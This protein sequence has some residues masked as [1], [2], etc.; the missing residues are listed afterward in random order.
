[1]VRGALLNF[2]KWGTNYRIYVILVSLLAFT[3]IRADYV[4]SYAINMELAV[5]PYFF[6]F[7][8]D[9]GITRM[10]FYFGVVLLFCNAPFV[11]NQQ[12]FVL[13]R[14]GRKHWFLGQMLYIL[15]ANLCFFLVTAVASVIVFVPQ[16]SFS[17]DW[18][19][20][21]RICAENN[22]AA[23]VIMHQEIIEYFEPWMAC[24]L[25]YVLNVAIGTFLGLVIF[26]GNLFR[27]RIFGPAIATGWIVLSNMIDVTQVEALKYISPVHWGT[28]YTLVRRDK[29]IPAWYVAAF[30]ICGSVFMG[31]LIMKKSKRYSLDAL[32]EI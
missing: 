12:M 19:T 26:Y 1:M 6:S 21:F 20:I 10:L 32:E 24:L 3:V 22:Q 23:G 16:V 15:L 27:S 7:Q 8:F 25:T 5:T 30:L 9:D 28:L 29:P 14:I 11:D 4:R 17:A 2:K 18:G 31:V 13:M